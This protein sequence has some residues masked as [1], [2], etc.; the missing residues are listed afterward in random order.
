MIEVEDDGTG[1]SKVPEF[2][3]LLN[4]KYNTLK[5]RSEAIGARIQFSQGKSGLL[6]KVEYSIKERYSQ[7]L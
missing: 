7:G 1:F 6:A 3:G 2:I 4:K 5:M